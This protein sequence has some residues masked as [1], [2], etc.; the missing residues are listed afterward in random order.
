MVYVEDSK[1]VGVVVDLADAL[2]QINQTGAREEIYNFSDVLLE[3]DFC[4]FRSNNRI[5]IQN[6]DSLI[7]STVGVEESGYPKSLLRKYPQIEMRI[8]DNWKRGFEL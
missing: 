4:I 1:T 6:I 5:D 2:L 3:S 7:G 8:V